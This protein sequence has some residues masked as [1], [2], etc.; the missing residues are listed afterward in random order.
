VVGVKSGW[1]LGAVGFLFVAMFAILTLQLWQVQVVATEEYVQA[2]EQSQVKF[3][4]TPAPRGQI[5]DRAGRQLAG[6][7]AALSAVVDGALVP[8]DAVPELV[9]LLTAFSGLDSD[10]VMAIVSDARD[11]GDRRVVVSDLSERDAVYLSEH[12]EDF[13]GVTVVAVPQR[14][15]PYGNLA[16]GVI[17]YIGRP[18]PADI[19]NGASST[20]I[21]GKAG[22]EKQYDQQLQGT[23]GAIKYQVDAQR[24]VLAVLGE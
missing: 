1:R 12:S 17:G 2:A 18:S 24:S 4:A 22:L 8:S 3:V 10:E 14:V 23:E 11:R 7:S 13:V 15:Y 5:V 6:T 19:E 20:D 21:L 9:S 16:S